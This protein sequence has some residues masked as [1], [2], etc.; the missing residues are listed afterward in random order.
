MAN[1]QGR[2]GQARCAVNQNIPLGHAHDTA[3][4]TGDLC[5]ERHERIC[6]EISES[7]A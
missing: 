6:A 2:P 4:I 3:L 7:D 1:K 5:V